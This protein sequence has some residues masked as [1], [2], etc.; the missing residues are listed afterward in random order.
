MSKRSARWFRPTILAL[1]L[2]FLSPSAVPAQVLP[3]YEPFAYSDGPVAGQ[4]GGANWGGG[5][6]APGAGNSVSA[7]GLAYQTLATTGGLVTTAGNNDGNFR[8]LGGSLGAAGTTV[9]VGFLA[10][11]NSGT[12]FANTYNG[13]S[14]FQG[15]TE[16][17]FM[18][19]P[20]TSPQYGFQQPGFGEQNTT[21][22]VDS[23]VHFFVFSLDFGAANTTVNMYVDP[24]PGL[25]T[26]D[27]APAV[28]G[29]SGPA[30]LFD[31][32]R[33]QGGL[34]GGTLL[35]FD[36][37]RLGDTFGSVAPVPEPGSMALCG[38]AA[39]GLIGGWRRRRRTG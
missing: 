35:N 23:T 19:Q 30:F 2:A 20:F 25:A 10:N 32:I 13:I 9:W 29:Y 3:A 16:R 8:A 28:A 12:S 11:L 5:W 31:N 15:N 39:S 33:V 1:S 14:L 36:E 21:T 6:T 22:A 37:I 4:N 26:P 38:L 17:L 34:G 18:G 27:V 24:T 7:T